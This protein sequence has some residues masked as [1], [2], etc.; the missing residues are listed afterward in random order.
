MV[1]A[2]L[3]LS[4]RISRLSIGYRTNKSRAE[5]AGEQETNK[6]HLKYK[7]SNF[8]SGNSGTTTN[9]YEVLIYNNRPKYSSEA[10]QMMK[11]RVVLESTLYE[12]ESRT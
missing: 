8:L 1:W 7:R 6:L 11:K 12:V 9:Y 5:L 2:H 10:L 4:K 3:S